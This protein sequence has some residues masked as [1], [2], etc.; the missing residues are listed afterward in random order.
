MQY[1]MFT[2]IGVSSLVGRDTALLTPMHVNMP[3][4]IRN[5]L[6]EDEP[7]RFETCRRHQKLNICL[8][9][10]AFLWFL[11][12][13]VAHEKPARH[14]VDQRGGRS[15]TLYRKLN[16]NAK[17]LLVRE[18]AENDLL[19]RQCTFVHAAAYCHTRDATQ[20]CQFSEFLWFLLYRVA[21]EK[22]ARHLVDQRG[23]RSRTLYR[24]LNAQKC[25]DVQGDHFRH[26]L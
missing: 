24:K 22:P 25:I 4:F 3:Y 23:R 20:R 26:L 13:R 17:Y 6:F 14:L 2:Y 16:A 11:L 19:V 18:G 9:T 8:E 10:C 12:Y 21:H 15:R 7:T 5:C 1:G